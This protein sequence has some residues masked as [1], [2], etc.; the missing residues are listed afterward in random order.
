MLLIGHLAMLAVAAIPSPSDL[1]A[2]E[3][4]RA[5]GDDAISAHVRPVLDAVAT[6]LRRVEDWAWSLTS[7]IRP[8]ASL[9]TG[10]FGLGQTWNMFGAPPTRGE[11]L[12]LRYFWRSGR[13]GAGNET[14]VMTATELV[15]PALPET[16]PRTLSSFWMGYRDKAISNAFGDYFNARRRLNLRSATSEQLASAGIDSLQPISQYFSS[17]FAKEHFAPGDLFVRVETWY[18]WV[19][20]RP[21]GDILIAPESRA[22]ALQRYRETASTQLA[23]L[24][25]ASAI[26]TVEREADIQWVLAFVK[27]P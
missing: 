21:R 2:A 15:F 1:A 5:S 18:G 23:P 26:D 24:S 4:V 12:R 11:Y 13:S 17:R 22:I 19:T 7:F 14:A 3:G 8:V 27:T 25:S 20:A 6:G 10:R 16:E 9:Y